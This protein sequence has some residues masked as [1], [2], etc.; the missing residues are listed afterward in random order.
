MQEFQEMIAASPLL[1]GLDP[2]LVALAATALLAALFGGLLVLALVRRGPRPEQFQALAAEALQ[3]NNEGFLALAAERLRAQQEASAVDL[4]G[5]H[6]AIEDLVN[7]LHEVVLRFQEEN[8]RLERARLSQTGEVGE[9][10]RAL[11]TQTGELSRALQ[12]P[13]ARGRWGELTL[14]RT[15]ELAGLSAHCDFAEQVTLGSGRGALRPDLLVRLPSGREIAVDAK[16]PLDAYLDASKAE[17][18]ADRAEALARHARQIKRHVDG[19]SSRGYAERLDRSPEFV[20]LFLPHDGFLSAAVEAD[21]D[22]VANAMERSVVVATPATLFALLAAVAQGWREQALA[23]NARQILAL[24]AEMDDRLGVVCE[25]LGKLGSSLTRSVDA[26]NATVGS[27]ESR[28]LVQ[29]RRVRELGVAGARSL[30][31]PAAVDV[32]A[33]TPRSEPTA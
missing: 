8:Q 26:Y 30:E 15:V 28:V 19:L 11:A 25:H 2:R 24:A 5:R 31:A 27:F 17:S 22:L 20:V 21:R 32:A 10:L 9:Q 7:P 16:V 18:D 29:A 4:D 23:E 6:K 12:A 33:R 14:R 1:Q 13:G 3:R